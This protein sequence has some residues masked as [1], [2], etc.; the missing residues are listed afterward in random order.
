MG[1]AVSELGVL[2]AGWERLGARQL[3]VSRRLPQLGEL[4]G[5]SAAPRAGRASSRRGFFV[6]K[7]EKNIRCF[8]LFLRLVRIYIR[9]WCLGPLLIETVKSV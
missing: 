2:G 7:Q 6:R 5:A 1:E 8:C 4:L 3:G 9:F